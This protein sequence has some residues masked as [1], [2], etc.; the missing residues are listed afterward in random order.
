MKVPIKL[1]AMVIRIYDKFL[2]KA[3]PFLYT[4]HWE[5]II[6]LISGLASFILQ[7]RTNLFEFFVIGKKGSHENK[8][9]ERIHV[10]VVELLYNSW[11]FSGLQ[12]EQ[13]WLVFKQC[14][15]DIFARD[16]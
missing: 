3:Y 10:A 2:N 16:T 1:C 13:T 11:I 14:I 6:K 8:F 7:V 9:P 4:D 15:H 5:Y 12:N